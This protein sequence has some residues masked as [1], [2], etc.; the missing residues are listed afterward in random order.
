LKDQGKQNQLS[1]NIKQL[2]MPEATK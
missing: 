1:E 2:A